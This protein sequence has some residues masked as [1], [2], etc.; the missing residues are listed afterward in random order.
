[1]TNLRQL[2]EDQR[3]VDIPDIPPETDISTKQPAQDLPPGTLEFPVEFSDQGSRG[4]RQG[5]NG[6][7]ATV[8]LRR[9]VVVVSWNFDC[10]GCF[11]LVRLEKGGWEWGNWWNVQ[12]WPDPSQSS[13]S[14]TCPTSTWPQYSWQS[15]Y[16]IPW[17]WLNRPPALLTLPT[18]QQKVIPW[19]EGGRGMMLPQ[20][21]ERGLDLWWDEPHKSDWFPRTDI[22]RRENQLGWLRSYS[23]LDWTATGPIRD[24]HN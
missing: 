13:C 20:K 24:T 16:W 6:G 2:L 3:I 4:G 14:P 11:R 1:M 5:F 21:L 10:F 19:I 17:Q 7:L 8:M 18:A 12:N 23:W 9:I 15:S 22:S